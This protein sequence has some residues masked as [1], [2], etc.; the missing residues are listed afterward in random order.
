MVC[1]R[2][3]Q[4]SYSYQV[5]EQYD[6]FRLDM[7]LKWARWRITSPASRL[8]TQRCIQAQIKE[9]INALS[10]AFVRGIH[11]WPVNSPH[12]WPVMQKMFPFDD[13]IMATC[14]IG[15]RY[16]FHKWFNNM[17]YELNPIFGNYMAN[18]S[19]FYAI[20][21]SENGNAPETSIN[22][23]RNVRFPV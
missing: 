15:F 12:K 9:N 19:L 7:I 11:R 3:V 8:F 10:L 18:N 2:L 22:W 13:V 23:H 16:L 20:P 17:Q 1:V 21:I 14:L 4:L 5:A 6:I